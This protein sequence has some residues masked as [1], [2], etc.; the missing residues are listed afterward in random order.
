MPRIIASN[1]V[2]SDDMLVS[3]DLTVEGV[4][5]TIQTTNL[6]IDD[7]NITMGDV[8]AISGMS[9]TT[10]LVTT[11]A[12]VIVES[13]TGLIPGMTVTKA[14]GTGIFGNANGNVKK[15]VSVD[16]TTQFTVDQNHQQAGAITFNI[17]AVSDD[18]ADGGGITLKGASDKTII[19]K[20]DTTAWEVNNHFYPDADSS[21]D[22][23]SDT[24]RWRN[25]YA[26][27][28]YSGDLHLTNERGSWTVIEEA[29]YL[30]IKNNKNGKRYKLLM[31][32][33]PEDED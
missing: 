22:L 6:S 8:A 24:I 15:I 7:K 29:N 3:G 18:T 21:R 30:T 11:D 1:S 13:T 23:G 32:E 16:S 25:I 10:N 5:T 27:N 12:V 2:I 26:D 33:L 14:S 4:T 31:E 20:S 9:T 28:I 19:W 17:G